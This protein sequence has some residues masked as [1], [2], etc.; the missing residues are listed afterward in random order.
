VTSDGTAAENR[1][2][3]GDNY[4]F[5]WLERPFTQDMTYVPDLDIA[6]FNLV[7]DEK[8][9]YVSI[10]LVGSNPN[11]DMGINYAV[12]LDTNADGFGDYIVVA[13]PPYNVSWS[14]DN[15]QV[16]QDTN[17]DT[18]GLSAER[19]DA[20]IPG[21]GYDA[22]IFDGGRGP[23]DDHD[24]AWVRVNAGRMATVQFA[25]KRSLSGERF[26]YGVISD[27]GIKDIGEFDYIDRFTPEEAGSPVRSDKNYPLKKLF[28][29]DTVCR[30]VFGFT[31]NGL[32][33][34]RCVEDL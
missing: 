8:F 17:K 28:A 13:H 9:F 12:E 33:P 32:E 30:Q 19:S 15:V 34:Q 31:G 27:G 4:K 5:N 25:F 6:S 22:I 26:M 14:T 16:A 7:Y 11:N 1:A 29:V 10:E 23:E 18:A 21:D 3:Y 24:L 20:P 2:P